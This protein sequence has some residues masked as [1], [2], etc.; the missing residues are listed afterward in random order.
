MNWNETN[1]EWLLSSDYL[2]LWFLV[3]N[4]INHELFNFFHRIL[5]LF[6]SATFTNMLNKLTF[7]K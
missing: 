3:N 4:V 2:L 7:M 5:K 6:L 1:F